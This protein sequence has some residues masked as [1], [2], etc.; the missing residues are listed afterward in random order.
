MLTSRCSPNYSYVL[1]LFLAACGAGLFTMRASAGNRNAR[2]DAQGSAR[3]NERPGSWTDAALMSVGRTR[4]TMTE[5]RD[6]NALVAGGRTSH[7]P[8]AATGT[9]ELY[10]PH[11]GVWRTTGSMAFERENFSATLLRDGRVLAAGGRR[12]EGN[13]SI[14]EA[15]A[16]IYDPRTGAW[17]FT[18]A[19]AGPRFQHAAAPLPDGRVLV[20][21]GFAFGRELE[22]AEIFD[23]ATGRWIPAPSMSE[24]RQA[25]TATALKD[26]R[27][28]L[29]GGFNSCC[30]IATAEVYNPRTGAWS[31]A[32]AMSVPRGSFDAA[33]LDDG[34][35]LVAGGLVADETVFDSTASAEVYDPRKQLLAPRR[36]HER[37]PHRRGTHRPA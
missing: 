18:G 26:G 13:A 28:L 30:S 10:V 6:G 16:E 4:F 24:M 5:L 8:R 2:E 21:G 35:V 22:T 32:G 20:A 19:M 12:F 31:P 7:F 1:A 33:L 17:M 3:P 25:P 27:V 9:A 14:T 36:R 11:K 15:S 29:A 37:E 23:P 34:R